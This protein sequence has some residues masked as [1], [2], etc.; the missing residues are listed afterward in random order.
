MDIRLV[1]RWVGL[2]AAFVVLLHV[3]TIV[4]S[5]LLTPDLYVCAPDRSMH[6]DHFVVS[7]LYED[8]YLSALSSPILDP[9]IVSEHVPRMQA[10][11]LSNV[12]FSGG[13][14]IA[15]V[16]IQGFP[17]RCFR[18]TAYYSDSGSY[19]NSEYFKN[20]HA[21]P[22]ELRTDRTLNE[23]VVAYGVMPL[24]ALVNCFIYV[25]GFLLF[26]WVV[27]HIKRLFRAKASAAT[28]SPT[29]C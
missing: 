7:G 15:W 3:I 4:V 5:R 27:R 20:S 18:S 11:L 23:F 26:C 9:K 8:R 17:L 1:L 24:P 12:S 13:N 16:D 21:W 10:P 22:R 29:V 14:A 6:F 25:N 2:F 28:P 19:K